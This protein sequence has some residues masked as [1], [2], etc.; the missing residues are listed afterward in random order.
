M[1]WN[2][3]FDNKKKGQVFYTVH[4][5]FH[6]MFWVSKRKSNDISRFCSFTKLIIIEENFSLGVLSRQDVMSCTWSQPRTGLLHRNFLSQPR[7]WE[8]RYIQ[9]ADPKMAGPSLI[10]PAIFGSAYCRIKN[11]IILHCINQYI[12]RHLYHG[13][14]NLCT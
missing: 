12:L 2:H 4:K 1:L 3:F 8:F 5:I 6:S 13:Y 7:H 11:S 10:R 9:Y 14:G